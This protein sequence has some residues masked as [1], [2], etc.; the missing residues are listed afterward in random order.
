ML[1]K[2]SD[3]GRGKFPN[4]FFDIASEYVPTDLNTIFQLCEYGWTIFGT[5]KSVIRRV[6]SY[7]ITDIDLSGE[8]EDELKDIKK[9]LL[10]TL[11]IKQE[12]RSFGEEALTYGNAFISVY[13]PFKR[14]LKCPKCNISYSSDAI[15]Y[16]LNTP[17]ELFVA[18][19]KKCGYKGAFNAE[20][21]R[22]ST[23]NGI[24]I[25]RW[26][27][28]E[29]IFKYSPI[30]NKYKYYWKIPPEL[31]SKI[32]QKQDKFYIETTPI[33]MLKAIVASKSNSDVLFEFNDN[34]IYHYK[35]TNLSGIPL[36]GWGMP[37]ILANFKLMYYMQILRRYDE[38]LA[39][40]YIIPFRILFPNTPPAP[41][42]GLAT[43]NFG[44]LTTRL[45]S[46]IDKRRKDP[47]SIQVA[48]FAIG[49][50]MAGGEAKAL[51][52]KQNLM[53]AIDEFLNACNFPAELYKGS[54]SIQAAPAA[55]RI[56]ENIWSHLVDA[57][58][59]VLNW[60]TKKV[61][62]YYSWSYK[63]EAK[64]TP[65]SLAE[66]LQMKAM[67]LQASAA[68]DI[69]KT[70]AYGRF[71]VDYKEEQRR[72]AKEQQEVAKIQQEAMEEAQASQAQMQMIQQA[73][74]PQGA[75]QQGGQQPPAPIPVGP[76]PSPEGATP[77]DI[78]DQAKQLAQEL[79]MAPETIRRSRLIDI[80]H[81]NPQLHALVKQFMTDMRQNAATQGQAMI[82]EQQRQQMMQNGGAAPQ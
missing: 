25:I 23:K 51:S 71:G 74:Q 7:F 52:P 48:P 42:D 1:S 75:P 38:A 4:P 50:Q 28:K 2:I 16:K 10:N 68:Q 55:L 27:P 19:C 59:D 35:N 69:S 45:V 49:Y 81:S 36:K 29:I 17:E 66:D 8:A 56:F 73:Q 18:E 22:V 21:I 3:T 77:G 33:H 24:S 5:Y 65:V 61:A 15:D 60:I 30:A 54:L 79:L 44:D 67:L 11:H 46:M 20:D 14:M 26:S 37:D 80:K 70:T 47:T 76:P 63:I 40:D 53:I 31:I 13:F 58:N 34:A 12:I 72:I 78:F 57:Y 82:L 9:F 41:N 6:A 64:F 62:S 32:A 39:F 43:Y